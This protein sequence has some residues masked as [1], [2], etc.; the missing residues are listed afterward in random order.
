MK[1]LVEEAVKPYL[2]RIAQLE[3]A[4]ELK[5]IDILTLKYAVTHL[6]EALKTKVPHKPG[7][8]ILYF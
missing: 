3:K 6:H 1:A 7:K 4:A 2:E 8:L 5:D